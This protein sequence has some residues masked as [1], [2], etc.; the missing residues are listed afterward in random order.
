M[1]A[2]A[3]A[4]SSKPEPMFGS[5]EAKNARPRIPATPESTPISTS[6]WM[7][8]RGIEMPEKLAA[9]GFDPIARTRCPKGVRRR[10]AVRTIATSSSTHTLTGSPSLLPP[11][12]VK[13]ELLIGRWL[14]CSPLL[15]AIARPRNIASVAS[16]ATIAGIFIACTRI[17]LMRPIPPASTVEIATAR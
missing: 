12:K 3:I 14:T 9:S 10:S 4:C 13:K 15:S 7:R 5:P 6:A 1:I 8:T 2:A 16:V 11:K 17:A